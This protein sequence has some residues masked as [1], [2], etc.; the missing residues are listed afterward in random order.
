MSCDRLVPVS[1]SVAGVISKRC[2]P[3][4]VAREVLG[5]PHVPLW[6]HLLYQALPRVRSSDRLPPSDVYLKC[7][8]EPNYRRYVAVLLQ[9]IED[10]NE[11]RD[12]AVSLTSNLHMSG[13]VIDES[14]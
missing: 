2:H 8:R 3:F 5:T 14:E 9:C 13:S 6:A 10:P 7:C 4:N 11:R 1:S 12:A